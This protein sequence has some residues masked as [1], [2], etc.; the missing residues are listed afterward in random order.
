MELNGEP[1]PRL[2]GLTPFHD[3]AGVSQSYTILL[4]QH[5]PITTCFTN[6]A[7]E[8]PLLR[9]A[10]RDVILLYPNRPGSVQ[11]TA[12]C[13]P[14]RAHRTGAESR[15]ERS[16]RRILWPQRQWKVRRRS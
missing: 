4:Q 11:V 3:N 12:P 13:V 14:S 7:M 5:S 9:S 6:Q 2:V 16:R 8:A 10:L 1:F 15:S